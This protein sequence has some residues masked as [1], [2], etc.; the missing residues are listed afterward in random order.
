MANALRMSEAASMGMH[1]MTL[2][3]ANVDRLLAARAMAERLGVSEAHLAK[4]LQRLA[5]AGLVRSVRGPKGGFE[6]AGDAR[7]ITLL[8]VYECLEGPLANGD[9]LLGIPIC[10][11]KACILG[12]LVG[13]INE[14]VRRRLGRTTLRQLA[15]VFRRSPP[16]ATEHHQD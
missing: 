4:V 7:R 13:S 9:C 10:D 8:D 14:Q 3:A 12:D 16:D 2:L 6:L 1:T 5:R 15:K 11:G